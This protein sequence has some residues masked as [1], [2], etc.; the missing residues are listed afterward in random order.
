MYIESI[1]CFECQREEQLR[2]TNNANQNCLTITCIK[3][4]IPNRAVFTTNCSTFII[5]SSEKIRGKN[6]NHYFS[7]VAA[8]AHATVHMYATALDR[9]KMALC[10]VTVHEA[11]LEYAYPFVLVA[12]PGCLAV[13]EAGR[14]E[15]V[16]RGS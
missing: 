6:A 2:G 10:D 5:L 1:Y 16:D 11:S 13:I 7:R 9:N 8:C 14:I 4:N 3:F 15:V 12:L